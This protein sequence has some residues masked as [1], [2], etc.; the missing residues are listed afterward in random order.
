[1]GENEF[2]GLAGVIGIIVCVGIFFVLR[3][4]FPALAIA[5]LI[6]ALIVVLLLIVLVIFIIIWAFRKPNEK[7]GTSVSQEI[8]SLQKEGRAVLIEIRQIGMR[9]KNQEIRK[10]NDEI[11]EAANRIIGEI[12]N[13]QGNI[14]EVRR[15]FNYYL[16][17]LEKILRNYEKL[18][19]A[20]M[21]KEETI[22]ST[23]KCLTNIKMTMEK[24]YEKLFGK[25]EMDLEVE[26]EV[27]NMIC[28]RDGLITDDG[29]AE[30]TLTI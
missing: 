22:Q 16:P 4:I 27:L 3:K 24:Q 1:M 11:C 28:K 9:L 13:H 25:C 7:E 6:G 15:L 19:R 14:L 29:E 30:I 20:G 21:V 23:F 26:M 17:T 2:S 12:R 18:E 5:L 10:K 8:S